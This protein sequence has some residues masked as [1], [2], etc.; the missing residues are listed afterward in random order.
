VRQDLA[1]IL[2]YLA[3]DQAERAAA[4]PDAEK[5]AYSAEERRLNDLARQCSPS[6]GDQ[7]AIRPQ[8]S[9]APRPAGGPTRAEGAARPWVPKTGHEL[10]LAAYHLMLQYEFRTAAEML[11]QAIRL[12][13]RD[14]FVY[15]ALGN[16]ELLLGR[17]EQ[18]LARLDTSIALWRDFYRSFFLRA[19]AKAMLNDHKA[20]LADFDEAIRLRPEFLPAY[21]DRALS[22][23]ALEDYAG[24]IAD[25]TRAID[26]DQPTRL[27]FVRAR[28]RQKAGDPEGAAR[29]YQEGL[30]RRPNDLLSWVARGRARADQSPDDALR[31]FDEALKLD[32]RSIPALEA[33][34]NVLSEKLGRTEEA[35]GVLDVAVDAYP[36]YPSFRSGRGVLLA[37]LG[38][39]QDALC[40][41]RESLR[42]DHQ[43]E[44]TYQVAG[45]Y[46]LTSRQDPADRA[47]A[48]R[49]LKTAFQKGYGLDLVDQDPDLDPIRSLPEFRRLVDAARFVRT[50]DPRSTP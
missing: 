7:S 45:I 35:I 15:Y 33:K 27:Y 28:V 3:A 49:L 41:A 46:A 32:P 19:G 37:R 2:V 6:Q 8:P 14:S 5:A 48:F 23:A 40:D 42:L 12:D 9:G 31:D 4:A 24:A 17:P 11:C 10:N 43:T 25:L 18:A 29:D 34:V 30:S 38:R 39:R 50:D 20:A 16:C 47:E 26:G 21:A 1:E 13:P 36:H 44:V 22:K